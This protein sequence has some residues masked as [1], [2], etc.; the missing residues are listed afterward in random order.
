[1]IDS[2]IFYKTLTVLYIDSNKITATYFS[3]V[4]EKLFKNV[5]VK[6]SAK[7]AI[8]CF[9][10]DKNKNIDVIICDMHLS[11]DLQ[12]VFYIIL[13]YGLLDFSHQLKF[14]L[15][16]DQLTCIVTMR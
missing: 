8:T 2:T 9:L 11:M 13:D 16:R 4:L 6:N 5:I 12:C 15:H 10:E 3:G 7:E 14:L 1:M